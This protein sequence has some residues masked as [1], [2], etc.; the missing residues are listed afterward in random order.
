VHA[1][2]GGRG[3]GGGG[4]QPLGLQEAEA[5]DHGIVSSQ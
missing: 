1:A 2:T 5:D 3:G 4:A